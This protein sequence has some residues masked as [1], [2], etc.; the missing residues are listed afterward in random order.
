[1]GRQGTQRQPAIGQGELKVDQTC[2]VVLGPPGA[3]NV[4]KTQTGIIV[5]LGQLL[6]Q[7]P[8][9][10]LCAVVSTSTKVTKC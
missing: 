2:G 5:A 6:E 1:M 3:S 4:S 7:D 10:L 9:S 8:D